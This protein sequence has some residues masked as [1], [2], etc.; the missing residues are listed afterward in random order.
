MSLDQHIDIWQVEAAGQIY[1]TNL[2]EIAN[3]IDDGRLT[4]EDKVRKGEL[5]WI[6]AGKVPLLISFF[7]AKERGSEIPPV[8]TS[9]EQV[10]HGESG[11]SDILPTDSSPVLLKNSFGN[12][13]PNENAV[14]SEHRDRSAAYVCS[15]CSGYYCSACP[16][17]Y[18]GS[19]RTC[20][21]CG[22]LC[23]PIVE[24]KPVEFQRVDRTTSGRSFGAAEFFESLAYPFKFKASFVLGAIMFM[25]FTT[26]QS[27][28][29]FG[30][31]FSMFGALVAAMFANALI[32]GVLA[33][34]VENFSQHKIGLD[35][36]PSFDDFSVWD[37]VM[38]PFFL[39]VAAYVVSFGPLVALIVVFFILLSGGTAK[40]LTKPEAGSTATSIPELP[41]AA[42]AAKQS[43]VVQELLKRNANVQHDRVRAIEN[44]EI[45]QD[46]QLS[47][48]Q[49]LNENTLKELTSMDEQAQPEISPTLSMPDPSSP[50]LSAIHKF[51]VVFLALAVLGVLWGFIY[52]PAACAVAGYTR[53]FGATL[54]PTVG[55]DTIRRLGADY[56]KVLAMVLVLGIA[57]SVIVIVLGSLLSMFELPFLGNIPAKA[58]ASVFNFYLGVVFACILGFAL[59]SASERLRLPC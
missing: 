32:F 20:P 14:C 44:G 19:V 48:V 55:L 28:A 43:E 18:G 51:G 56:I 25:L 6:A 33:N 35:F 12:T 59:H 13:N 38:H 41:S 16:R 52:F 31:I 34:T 42:A 57:A 15:S 21:K 11:N 22:E 24:P 37:D 7:N 26:A 50:G 3:W 30:G 40:E 29:G 58:L 9:T 54:N 45:P 46:G 2:E 49:G 17:S 1:S 10:H 27:V 23:H 4:R 47:P 36:M 5:R 8:V 53:S 39:S